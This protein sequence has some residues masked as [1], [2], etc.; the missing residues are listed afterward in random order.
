MLAFINMSTLCRLLLFSH[1]CRPLFATFA[2]GDLPPPKAPSKA[3]SRGVS[4]RKVGTL[5][6]GVSHA[7]VKIYVNVSQWEDHCRDILSTIATPDGTVLPYLEEYLQNNHPSW[8]RLKVASAALSDMCDQIGQLPKAEDDTSASVTARNKREIITLIVGAAAIMGSIAGIVSLYQFGQIAR[9]QDR[10]DSNDDKI[11]DLILTAQGHEA[12]LAQMGR[13][14]TAI[15]EAVTS[16]TNYIKKVADQSLAFE[17]NFYIIDSMK[18]FVA[19]A[20]RIIDITAETIHGKI[21]PKLMTIKHA[22]KTLKIISDKISPMGYI[23]PFQGPYE[24]F[25]CEAAWVVDHHGYTVII[26]V[27]IV[28]EAMSELTLYKHIIVPWP[29]N[30]TSVYLTLQPANFAEYLATNEAGDRSIEM[31]SGRLAACREHGQLYLC[32]DSAF[33]FSPHASCLVA[34][35]TG[36]AATLQDECE[37]RYHRGR[38]NAVQTGPNQ[39]TLFAP[40]PT[41]ITI[42]CSDHGPPRRETALGLVVYNT[43]PAC[44]ISAPDGVVYTSAAATTIEYQVES[45]TVNIQ[46]VENKIND[47]DL[48]ESMDALEDIGNFAPTVREITRT[49]DRRRRDTTAGAATSSIERLGRVVGLI[50]DSH[51]SPWRWTW[52]SL[53]L[54]ILIFVMCC[55]SCAGFALMNSKI[56]EW[57]KAANHW[58]V[59]GSA[60]RRPQPTAPRGPALV[61]MNTLPTGNLRFEDIQAAPPRRMHPLTRVRWAVDREQQ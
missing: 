16:S 27:P 55:C 17:E 58:L 6:G 52:A 12:D 37:P 24:F 21:S 10:I 28:P 22:Q 48:I 20:Q 2:P 61:E 35:F 60:L 39:V 34:L 33:S 56:K 50:S 15:K 57:T 44:R 3:H 1:I 54:A 25:N 5:M 9:A 45:F 42:R 29:T 59:S 41:P 53:A 36:A 14:V 38:F 23:I 47:D 4:F 30:V 43:E 13:S 19:K 8:Q 31:T 40:T 26:A 11:Y 7:F 51:H 46:H 32:A 49:N 18:E